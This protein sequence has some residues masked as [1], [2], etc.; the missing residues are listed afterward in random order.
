MRIYCW[1]NPIININLTSGKITEEH[2][3]EKL[4]KK[5]LIG[6]GISDW[7]LFNNTKLG[8]TDPLSPDNVIIFGIGLLT[9]T[10]FPGSSRTSIVSLNVLTNGYGESSSA[11]PFA[12]K[13]KKAGYDGKIISGKSSELVYIWIKNNHIE[14]RSASNLIGKTTFETDRLIKAEVWEEDAK[15]A[16]IGPAGEKL[17][18][19]A[20]VNCANKYCGRCGM[21]AIM[22]SK[23]LKAIAVQGTGTIELA[24]PVKFK[25]ISAMVMK[26]L[27][28]DPGLKLLAEN[29]MA[30]A[31]DGAVMSGLQSVKNYQGTKFDGINNVG[32]KAVKKYIK[33]IIHCTSSCPVD[34][35]RLVQIDED[36]PYG[37]TVV[38]SMEATPAY[39]MAH[40]LIDDLPTVIKA[41]ELCNGYGI[42]MHSW[43]TV[44]QWAIECFERGILTRYDTDKLELRWRDG[45]L[46]LESIRRIA[47]REGTFANLL[48]EGVAIA[49]KKIGRGSEKYAMQM[50][51][52]EIDDDLRVCK[53]YGFGIMVEPRGPGHTLSAYMGEM[54]SGMS[55]K[56]AKKLY[57]T[58]NVSKPHVCDD[59]ADLVVLTERYGAIHDCLGICWIASQ[60]MAPQIIDRY[61]M[62]TYAKL[63]ATV[64]GWDISEK[65]LIKIAERILSIERS[66]N[67]LSGLERKDDFPPDRFYEPIPDGIS[68]GMSLD[69][70]IINEMLKRHSGLH[71]WDPETGVPNKETLENLDLKDVAD[72]L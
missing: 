44:M 1:G 32:Y 39:N 18:R 15:T 4:R 68:K 50:K 61:N 25:E 57:G 35:D 21:G 37:G 27:K 45:P 36:D 52:M 43:S 28:E 69:K 22:G 3:S 7:L 10:S 46:L 42:D 29:S 55:P 49:S 64:T 56:K 47:K 5:F 16:T 26:L 11:R 20:C 51:G 13:L 34:C 70:K 58:E 12:L 17:V 72:N 71:G 23:N 66:I 2:V 63:I 65:E 53:G 41:F 8:E 60:R 19:Y 31:A 54:D 67:I 24:N 6:R 9:G 59:K 40:F 14:I 62:G 48:A 30:S 38:S 33:N